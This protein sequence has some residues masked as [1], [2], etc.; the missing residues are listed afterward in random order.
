MRFNTVAS[1]LAGIPFTGPQKGRKLYNHV[2]ATQPRRILELGCAHGVT[3]CYMAAALDEIG[4]GT[5]VTMDLHTALDRDPNIDTL[6]ERLGLRE[7]IEPMFAAS[8]FTWELRRLLDADPNPQFDFAFQ[9]GGHTWD[10]AGFSFFLID[11]LLNPGG[12]IL[13]DDLNW[14][15]EGSPSQR[16][17]PKVRALSE[18]ER[19]IPQVGEVFR[20]LV[21]Q[22][23]GY[24][25][26]RLDDDG[27]WGWA[28]K[29]STPG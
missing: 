21:V 29:R 22:H 9:D 17:R 6:A 23:P 26:H 20:L 12:W 3:A 27:N 18:E 8:S 13:F 28:R 4:S 15:L 25:D 2:L 11:R 7:Y 19:T 24:T 1:E 10:V 16:H 14:T 5:I